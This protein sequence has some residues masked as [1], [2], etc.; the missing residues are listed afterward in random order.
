MTPQTLME[1]MMKAQMVEYKLLVTSKGGSFSGTSSTSSFRSFPSTRTFSK[2]GGS[3]RIYSKVGG[4]S[5]NF[6]P[7]VHSVGESSAY[8]SPVINSALVS[9]R[10]GTLKETFSGRA[11]GQVV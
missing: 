11:S 9:Q 5:G 4:N 6:P 3:S 10:R 2:E 7:S 1:L 8:V